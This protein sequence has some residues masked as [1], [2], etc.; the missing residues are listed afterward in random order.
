MRDRRLSP[1]DCSR[2][3]H[4]PYGAVAPDLDAFPGFHPGLFSVPPAG[5]RGALSARGDA[6]VG[7]YQVV[8]DVIDVG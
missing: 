5:R 4:C 3:S 8:E 6:G 7:V 1:L 2:I